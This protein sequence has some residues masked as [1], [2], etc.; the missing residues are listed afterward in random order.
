M[1]YCCH[2]LLLMLA[3]L[4]IP[5]LATSRSSITTFSCA[6]SVICLL[7]SSE[8]AAANLIPDAYTREH[9]SFDRAIRLDNPDA[10]EG[11]Y[12]GAAAKNVRS[13]PAAEQTELRK[14]FAAIDSFAKATGLNLHLPDTVKMIKTMGGEEFGAE[15]YTRENRIML[16]TGVL[17]IGPY[18]LA[19]ELWH[20]ISRANETVRNRAYA[21]FH[22]KPCNNIAYKPA[23]DNKVITNPDCPY[24]MH[25]IT[26]EK[27]GRPQ[28][29]TL[30]LYSKN[31]YKPGATMPYY[32]NIGLLALTGDDAHK[33]PLITEGKPVIYELME[34]PD[35]FKQIGTNTQYVLHVEEV[36][37]EH[38]AALITGGKMPQ[39]EYVER[40]R[41]ALR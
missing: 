8:A 12:L 4:S 25:Y 31:G 26:L 29:M 3:F 38:F 37:A 21:A 13:W 23:L 35:F 14:A 36:T 18:L 30:I 6:G 7:D 20:V 17:P 28:D 24:V 11:D 15:G 33:K 39:M 40:V 16:N 2:A 41:E 5:R 27:D 1:K 32:V 34:T 10:T 19:H 22:F 9:T